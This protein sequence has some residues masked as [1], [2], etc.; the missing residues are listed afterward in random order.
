MF[1]AEAESLGEGLRVRKEQGRS[2]HRGR[3]QVGARDSRWLT[4]LQ[5]CR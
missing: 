3:G 5:G 4:Y 1:P 2:Q